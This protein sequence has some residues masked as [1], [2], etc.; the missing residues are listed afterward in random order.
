MQ[1]YRWEKRNVKPMLLLNLPTATTPA[2][3]Q[4]FS[5]SHDYDYERTPTSSDESET[6]SD[7]YGMLTDEEMGHAHRGEAATGA[8]AGAFGRLT[9]R[10][11]V[12]PTAPPPR[13]R[14]RRGA[15]APPIDAPPSLQKQGGSDKLQ[16]PPVVD[17]APILRRQGGSDNVQRQSNADN[18][19]AK[20]EERRDERKQEKQGRKERRR[21]RIAEAREKAQE[22]K[23]QSKEDNGACLRH[24]GASCGSVLFQCICSAVFIF[25][26]TWAA[27]IA[28]GV[29]EVVGISSLPPGIAYGHRVGDVYRS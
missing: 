17:A 10:A 25:G 11:K 12:D 24:C 29:F 19:L 16:R 1:L 18:L 5:Q 28:L 14:A 27:F 6:D 23:T 13:A 3:V 15:I 20:E 4:G 26:A 8:G 7:D 2:S 22:T 21:Q 9:R